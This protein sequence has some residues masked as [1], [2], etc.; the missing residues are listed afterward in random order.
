MN[1]IYN[2]I[3]F[4]VVIAVMI[5]FGIVIGRATVD[6]ST[7]INDYKNGKYREIIIITGQDTTYKY[8]LLQEN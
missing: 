6:H 4:V 8:K 7:I 1:S 2:I 3:L 5:G